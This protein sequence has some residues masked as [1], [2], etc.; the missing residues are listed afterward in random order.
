M[1]DNNAEILRKIGA[2]HFDNWEVENAA[3]SYEKFLRTL[4][5]PAPGFIYYTS[6]RTV[7]EKWKT[8]Q[9]MGFFKKLNQSDVARV[10]LEAVRDYVKAYGGVIE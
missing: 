10:D 2:T 9:L 6:S 5:T 3:I 8:L 7:R 1:T 4:M